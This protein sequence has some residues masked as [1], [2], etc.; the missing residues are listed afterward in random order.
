LKPHKSLAR[1]PQRWIVWSN[2]GFYTPR[3]QLDG[4]YLASPN[5]NVFYPKPPLRSNNT[6]GMDPFDPTDPPLQLARI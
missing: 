2:A 6:R 4:H 5:F 1:R 3:E